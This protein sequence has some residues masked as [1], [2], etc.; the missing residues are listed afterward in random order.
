MATVV[1]SLHAGRCAP[2]SLGAAG[3]FILRLDSNCRSS[4]TSRRSLGLLMEFVG[5]LLALL[6]SFLCG[7]LVEWLLLQGLFR[8]MARQPLERIPGAQESAK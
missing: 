7:L 8:L 3:P 1:P 6:F 2:R 5:S 4:R